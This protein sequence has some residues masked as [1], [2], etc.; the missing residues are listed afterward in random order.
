MKKIALALAVICTTAS[1]FAQQNEMRSTMPKNDGT[2]RGVYIGLDYINLTDIKSQSTMKE[3]DTGITHSFDDSATTHAGVAGLRIGYSRTPSFGF[4]F[5]AGLRMLE[6]FNR[7]ESGD[8]KTQIFIPEG[9]MLFALS[10]TFVP[11]LGLNTSVWTGSSNMNELHPGPGAQIG[12][13]IQ[14]NRSLALNVGYTFVSQTIK[15]EEATYSTE[16]TFMVGGFTSN[17]NYTF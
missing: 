7:S 1:A 17:M 13:G 11:Y 9:N 15:Q 12:M 6:T 16:G 5:N 10:E 2:K 3:K 14:F 4:G 8:Q